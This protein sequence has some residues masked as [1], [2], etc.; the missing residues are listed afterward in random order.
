M[1]IVPA[2]VDHLKAQIT[3]LG[4]HVA[5]SIELEDAIASAKFILPAGFVLTLNE[6]AG[7]N[8]RVNSIMQRVEL[9]FGVVLAVSNGKVQNIGQ[10]YTPS[11]LDLL[12]TA[13]MKAVLGWQPNDDY[14]P[15]EFVRGRLVQV[16][17]KALWWQDEFK[18]AF[19]RSI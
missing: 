18:T 1:D 10:K 3:D 16:Q 15:A 17:S 4:G 12:R 6:V 7:P 14:D 8:Q 9:T 5:G 2:L 11:K 13:V 19:Y